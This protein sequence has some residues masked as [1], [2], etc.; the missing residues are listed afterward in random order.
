MVKVRYK[1]VSPELDQLAGPA[2]GASSRAS[3]GL[4][5]HVGEFYYISL[6]SLIP[7]KKQA[8][9]KFS[10]ED[11]ENLANTIKEH[12][13][14][15][16]LTIIKSDNEKFEIVSGERRF[17]AAKL[18][19]IKKVPCII[20]QGEDE[21]EEV[22]LIENVQR[23]DLHPVEVADACHSLLKNYEHGDQQKLSYKLGL[24]KTKIS[25]LL[26][27]ANLP[28]EIKDHLLE[29]NIYQREKLREI[30]RCENLEEMKK[31]LG[32]LE[33]GGKKINK[34]NLLNLYLDE[35]GVN[36]NVKKGPFHSEVKREIKRTLEKF[37][38]TL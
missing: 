38:K 25:E 26:T 8:R 30:S 10:D 17:K 22:A 6:D 19:G 21:A 2:V 37:L 33:K 15:Q 1:E 7:Y 27:I 18:A 12:G 35:N 13:V 3:V 5:D 29:K 16:P 28:Q 20:I 24:S 31:L 11:L 4:E 32:L 36:L 23:K 34:K 14:R 9:K